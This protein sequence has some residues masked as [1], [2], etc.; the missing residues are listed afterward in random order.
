MAFAVINSVSAVEDSTCSTDTTGPSVVSVDP[1]NNSVNVPDNKVIKVTFNETIN[2][3]E[4]STIQLKNKNTGEQIPISKSVNDNVLTITPLAKLLAGVQ[5]TLFLNNITDELGN[6]MGL[7]TSTFTTIPMKG[8][9]MHY[10]DVAGATVAYLQSKGITDV[11]V[12]TR[13]SD[14]KTHNAELLAAISKFT[15]AG[16]NVH[17]WIVCFKTGNPSYF[18]CPSGYYVKSVYVKTIRYWGWKKKAYKVKK[19]VRWKKVR[20][21]WKYKYKIVIRYKWRKGWIYKPIYKTVSGYDYTYRNN[22]LNYIQSISNY[23]NLAGIHLDY[24]RYSGVASKGH[25]AYQEPGGATAAVNAVTGFVQQVNSKIRP[26][27][28]LSA[29]VMPECGNNPGYYGQDYSRLADYLDFFVPMTYEGNY[30]T[31]NSWIT[32]VTNYIVSRAKG[33]PVYDGFTTYV[34]DSN[35]WTADSDL[36]ADVQSAK[37]GGAKGFVLFRYGT[38]GYTNVPAW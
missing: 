32:S 8:Y 9:W 28:L 14:G 12:L 36:A 10:S 31:G 15:P 38:S 26:G 19:K 7:Y 5:Y 20:G 4:N 34:S 3:T 37:A 24:V 33:K 21:K 27:V 13:G 1:V 2:V 6:G 17:A 11:F 18:V 25:A 23:A 30:N 16:I 22:L 35:T 29:A